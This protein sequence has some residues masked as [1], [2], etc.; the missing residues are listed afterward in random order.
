MSS[1]YAINVSIESLQKGMMNKLDI[2]YN[3]YDSIRKNILSMQVKSR[4][5]NK[6]FDTVFKTKIDVKEIE[7]TNTLVSSNI[8]K[9]L[10]HA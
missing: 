9:I 7:M 1:I 5:E 4:L 3:D 6:I 8:K 2:K 10:T